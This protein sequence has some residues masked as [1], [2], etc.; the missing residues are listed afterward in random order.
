M[1]PGLSRAI[2]FALLGFVLG[3]FIVLIVRG[4]Q[5]MQP[6]WSP[7]VGLVLATF[8]CAGFFVWGMGAFDPKMSV[9]G[10]HAEEHH[11]SDDAVPS[12]QLLGGLTWQ[13]VTLLIGF[14]VVTFALGAYSGLALTITDNPLASNSIIGLNPVVV[15]D[16]THL[17][18]LLITPIVLIAPLIVAIVIAIILLRPPQNGAKRST[19]DW[20]IRLV[21][22]LA[23]FGGG[24]LFA[25]LWFDTQAPLRGPPLDVALLTIPESFSSIVTTWLNNGLVSLFGGATTIY[26]SQ[27]VFFMAFIA[28]T[29]ISL[30]V[31]GGLL[32]FGLYAFSQGMATTKAQ[33]AARSERAKAAAALPTGAAVAA[34]PGGT[35]IVIEDDDR[36]AVWTRVVAGIA[37]PLARFLRSVTRGLQ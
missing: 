29:I 33:T 2:P 25:P 27:L 12:S 6:V 28:F 4:L 26:V 8:M 31:I 18:I 23:L 17:I 30:V 22:V 11:A 3:A 1:Q 15:A 16:L 35:T 36:P 19:R 5:S 20:L 24:S 10:E 9:H 14:I 34:L 32:A 37:R 13:L 7:G 21:I